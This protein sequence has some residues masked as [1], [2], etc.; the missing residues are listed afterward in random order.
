MGRVVEVTED[1]LRQR[2]S[3]LLEQIKPVTGD[4]LATRA[5]AGNLSEDEW[6]V[7]DELRSIAFLLDE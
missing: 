4:D 1:E 3:A 2:R 7:W 5:Q 6:D